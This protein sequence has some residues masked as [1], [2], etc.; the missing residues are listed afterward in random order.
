MPEAETRGKYKKPED[1]LNFEFKDMDEPSHLPLIDL[2]DD[3]EEGSA[4]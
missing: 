1:Y 4:T 2:D 3:D